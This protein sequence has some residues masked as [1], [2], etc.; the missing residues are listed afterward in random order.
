M[1]AIQ[2][3]TAGQ[4]VLSGTIRARHET[5]VAFQIGGRVLARHV[6]SGQAVKAGQ[7]LFS[8]DGRDVAASEQAASAQLAAAEAALA[9]AQRELVRQRQLVAQGFVS[10]Q[11]LDRFELAQRD[12]TSRLDVARSGVAQARN[13]RGYTELK[14]ARAGVITE[15]MAEAGQVV[16]AGQSLATLAQAGAREVEVYLPSAPPA[17]PQGQLQG[18]DG[19]VQA[20]QLREVAG[21]ADPA[22][23]AWRARYRLDA[24][25]PLDAWPLGGVVRLVLGHPA[26]AAAT[27][28]QQVP[29]AALDERAQ[30]PR[31]WRVVD[32]KAEAVP[33]KVI[34]LGA[35][36]ARIQSPLA[37]GDKVV[38][39]GTHRLT[40]GMALRELAP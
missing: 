25:N 6:E 20:V 32:G 37:V 2:P 15:V 19:Q 29:L 10:A 34:E 26:A 30:G 27:P 18:P 16:G 28:L 14:A 40:P 31:L 12:A 4:L 9:T 36:Q 22:S 8:L 21:A 5:P 39:L 17:P 11:T 35:S 13:A 23:R 38:A 1:V 24:A 7:L 3:A 33:V